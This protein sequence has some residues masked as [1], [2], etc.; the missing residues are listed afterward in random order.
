[1]DDSEP[2][3]DTDIDV[4]SHLIEGDRDTRFVVDFTVGPPGVGPVT[5]AT[6]YEPHESFEHQPSVD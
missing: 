4:S 6:P 5:S 3:P 1:M 2:L